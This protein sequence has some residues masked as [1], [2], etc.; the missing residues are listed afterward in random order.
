MFKVF[1]KDNDSTVASKDIR[2]FICKIGRSPLS[3][4]IIEEPYISSEHLIIIL[5]FGQIFLID[6]SLNGVLVNERKIEKNV[7]VYV[8]CSDKISVGK[9][10]VIIENVNSDVESRT[11]I[12][13]ESI[14]GG[15]DTQKVI[16]IENREGFVKSI[17]DSSFD[18]SY[19][20]KKYRFEDVYQD[21]LLRIIQLRSKKDSLFLLFLSNSIYYKQNFSFN[22]K[23]I[24]GLKIL[25][26]LII[27]LLVAV[28]FISISLIIYLSLR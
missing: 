20:I 6:K 28:F 21:E 3:D 18:L 27:S 15:L 24:S 16:R 26:Y 11:L 14:L 1:L 23:K 2:G 10:S 17:S 9:Y 8:K 22:N 25:D 13:F 19:F 12:C 5:V 7:P 4:I